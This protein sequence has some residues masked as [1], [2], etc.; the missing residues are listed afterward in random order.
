MTYEREKLSM[1]ISGA[2]LERQNLSGEDQLIFICKH[3]LAVSGEGQVKSRTTWY[4]PV[5]FYCISIKMQH[6]RFILPVDLPLR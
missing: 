1:G 3:P 6:Q 2:P 5:H 4:H